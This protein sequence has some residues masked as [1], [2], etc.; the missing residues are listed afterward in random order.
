MKCSMVAKI[1]VMDELKTTP[2]G[3]KYRQIV[4]NEDWDTKVKFPQH[5]PIQATRDNVL[6]SLSKFHVGDV[7]KV[8][9]FVGGFMRKSQEGFDRYYP[10]LTM[11]GVSY[12]TE[13]D[14]GPDESQPASETDGTF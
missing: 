14:M 2:K 5:I 10:K 13:A 11:C 12:A 9:F 8:E 3:F 1:E 6:S 7:V 4:V